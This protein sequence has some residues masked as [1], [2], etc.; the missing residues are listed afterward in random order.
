M[1]VSVALEW[2]RGE[3][4]FTDNK[5][6]RRHQLRFDGGAQ[7]AYSSSPQLVRA[8]LSDPS[9]VDPEESLL[10]AVASC[11][12]LWFLA[13]AAK[14]GFCVDAYQD[15]P[16]AAMSKN[17]KGKLFVSHI[18][19]RPDVQFSG[20][21]LPTQEDLQHLHHAA[22]EECNIAHSVRAEVVCEGTMRFV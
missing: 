4:V 11:H 9:A 6:S 21:K 1:E 20:G 13:L 2:Q 5:Y 19:L 16:T 15:A 7:V 12:M 14:Q 3:Q 8:P 10:A 22:H 18:T 17:E